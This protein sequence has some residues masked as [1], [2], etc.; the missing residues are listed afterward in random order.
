MA[1]SPQSKPS[2]GAHRLNSPSWICRTR[3][4][5]GG[6]LV[7]GLVGHVQPAAGPVRRRRR[8][9]RTQLRVRSSSGHSPGRPGRT[10]ATPTCLGAEQ[11]DLAVD[12]LDEVEVLLGRGRVVGRL[13][14]RVEHRADEHAVRRRARRRRSRSGRRSWSPGRDLGPVPDLVHGLGEQARGSLPRRRDCSHCTSSSSQRGGERRPVG[15]AEDVVRRLVDDGVPDLASSRPAT[16][17][18]SGWPWSRC[19]RRG[20]RCGPG[21]RGTR[22]RR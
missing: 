17:G 20:S 21:P 18:P 5:A 11:G 12:G 6:S 14:E 3:M 9:S 16:V 19:R 15:L 4:Q 10:A 7:A 2:S 13:L 8:P 1:S 22:R